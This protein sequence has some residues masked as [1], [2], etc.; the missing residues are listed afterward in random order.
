MWRQNFAAFAPRVK[1]GSSDECGMSQLEALERALRSGDAR[2]RIIAA[3]E[4]ARAGADGARALARAALDGGADIGVRVYSIHYL[5]A[6]A[7]DLERTLAALLDDARPEVRVSALEKTA[8]ARVVALAAR[9]EALTRDR[10]GFDGFEDYVVV[11]DV[12]ARVL[13]TLR[14]S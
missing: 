5:P 7:P 11:G 4:L 9:V 14:A 12:A 10:E 2:E 6:D 8:S 13:A 3:F 1:Y